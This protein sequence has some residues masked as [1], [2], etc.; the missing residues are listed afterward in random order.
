[1][2]ATDKVKRVAAIYHAIELASAN[3][4]L[5]LRARSKPLALKLLVKSSKAAAR[6]SRR[7]VSP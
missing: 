1:M 3:A 7:A 2:L 6:F 5:R 4:G